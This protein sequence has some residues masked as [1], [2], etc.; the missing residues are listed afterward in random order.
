MQTAPTVLLLGASGFVGQHTVKSLCSSG[1]NVYAQ[2]LP[3]EKIASF[4]A[5]HWFPC[6]LRNISFTDSLPSNCDSVIFLAQSPEFRNFPDGAESIFDINVSAVFKTIEYARKAG[7]R[8]FIFASTGSIYDD[9]SVLGREIDPIS[10]TTK[11]G[12]YAASKLAAEILLKPYSE[13]MSVIILRLF[14]PYGPGLNP[15]MLLPE[16]V[17]RVREGIPIDLHGQD[18]MVINPI[19]ID[20]LTQ[21]LEKCLSYEKSITLNIAGADVV[22]LRDIGLLIGDILGIP[23][24]FNNIS[25]A[26]PVL[27]GDISLL[28][29]ELEFVPKIS[30]KEGLSRWLAPQHNLASSAKPKNI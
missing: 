11:R 6:D 15:N 8:R 28:K 23:P 27:A 29:Q 16:L 21:L 17:R 30:I 4:L 12:F 26:A 7:A 13:C 20:D 1:W 25:G 5:G 10:V 14:M 3:N 22:S 24:K 2:H 19:Y 9:S 18:G